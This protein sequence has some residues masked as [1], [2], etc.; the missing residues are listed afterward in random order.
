MQRN[1]CQKCMHK[2]KTQTK[3]T[4]TQE[5]QCVRTQTQALTHTIM[6]ALT[7]SSRAPKHRERARESKRNILAHFVYL[8]RTQIVTA[9]GESEWNSPQPQTVC[10]N[11]PLP[12]LSGWLSR[13][14][15]LSPNVAASFG[16]ALHLLQFAFAAATAAA[17]VV[18]SFLPKIPFNIDY[19][20]SLSPLSRS[21]VPHRWPLAPCNR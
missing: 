6:H 12:P 7:H 4:K 8:Q 14:R 5:Q 21:L 15:T 1:K 19:W 10:N 3:H 18:H 11:W 20:F 2:S 13:T 17:A 9:Q 16:H